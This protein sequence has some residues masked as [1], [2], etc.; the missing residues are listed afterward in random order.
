MRA[1]GKIEVW[2]DTDLYKWFWT[3]SYNG[4]RLLE[5]LGGGEYILCLEG[6][7]SLGARG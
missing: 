6:M 5:T 2:W 7:W 4:M 1:I 3:L